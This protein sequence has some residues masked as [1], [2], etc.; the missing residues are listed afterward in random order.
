MSSEYENVLD[1]LCAQGAKRSKPGIVLGSL[2][3]CC[4]FS[5]PHT[6]LLLFNAL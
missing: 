2:V 1:P 6:V 5:F 4:F 3:S